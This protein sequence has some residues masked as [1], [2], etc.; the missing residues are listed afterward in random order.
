MSDLIPAAKT[1]NGKWIDVRVDKLNATV[2]VLTPGTGQALP[3]DPA[4]TRKLIQALTD[5][6]KTIRK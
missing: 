3:M 6:L 4:Q 2:T 5:G 1:T